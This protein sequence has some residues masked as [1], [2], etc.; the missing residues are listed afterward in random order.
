MKV[1]RALTKP[2]NFSSRLLLFPQFE[3]SFSLRRNMDLVTQG[4]LEILQKSF[5]ML[6]PVIGIELF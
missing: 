2:A 4:Q 3:D 5:L 6:S 1:N